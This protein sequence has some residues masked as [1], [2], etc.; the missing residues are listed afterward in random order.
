MSDTLFFVLLVAMGAIWLHTWWLVIVV[1]PKKR[2]HL[3]A[4][5]REMNHEWICSFYEADPALGR[6][7]FGVPT[8][9]EAVAQWD[10]RHEGKTP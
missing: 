9:G 4:K 3:L 7:L 8:S 2:A 6:R 1:Y 5:M 10:R